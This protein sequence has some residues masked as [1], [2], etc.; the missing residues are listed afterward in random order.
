MGGG[1]AKN[2]IDLQ[3]KCDANYNATPCAGERK[4]AGAR[5]MANNGKNNG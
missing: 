5:T 4:G 2:T 1:L 3:W